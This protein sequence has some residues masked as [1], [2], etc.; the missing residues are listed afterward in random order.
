MPPEN[1]GKIQLCK[2][3]KRDL[4]RGLI[5]QKFSKAFPEA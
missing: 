2:A 3:V 5:E 1:V 4:V